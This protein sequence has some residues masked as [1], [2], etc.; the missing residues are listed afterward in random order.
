MVDESQLEPWVAR[1]FK[2]PI[3]SAMRKGIRRD[4]DAMISKVDVSGCIGTE[5]GLV[6]PSTCV[7]PWR[8]AHC[9]FCSRPP[10]RSNFEVASGSKIGQRTY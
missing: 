2:V 7:H 4:V 10:A 8:P 6:V 1:D 9:S 5:V 3:T